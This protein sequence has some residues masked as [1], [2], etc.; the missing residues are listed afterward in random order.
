LPN[1]SDLLFRAVDGVFGVDSR[2]RIVL[3]NDGCSDL[4]GIPEKDVLGQHCYKVLRGIS[5]MGKPLCHGKCGVAMLADGGSETRMFPLILHA[6][7]GEKLRLWVNI[8]LVPS[9]HDDSWIWVHLLRRDTPL[10]ILDALKGPASESRPEPERSLR[11]TAASDAAAHCSLTHRERMVV[12]LLAE[13]LSTASIS[14]I[15][16]IRTVTVRNHIQNIQSKLGVHSRVETVAY[17]YR[18]NLVRN[19]AETS[20]A[21][22]SEAA[23]PI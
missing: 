3:W 18:H 16:D 6:A 12:E 22:I 4:L 14:K 11:D 19:L 8:I 20:D 17:A 15:L 13:G 5:P 21:G 7:A 2:Q 23:L 1:L 9:V 10:N